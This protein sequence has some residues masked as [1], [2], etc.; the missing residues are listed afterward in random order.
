MIN[1]IEILFGLGAAAIL[2]GLVL[3]LLKKKERGRKLLSL[4]IAALLLAVVLELYVRY[5]E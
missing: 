3:Y 2:G 4:G 1:T 5:T